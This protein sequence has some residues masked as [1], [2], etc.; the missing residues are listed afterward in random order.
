MPGWGFH[1]YKQVSNI[2][3]KV[4]TCNLNIF[5]E[6]N[7]ECFYHV[8]TYKHRVKIFGIINLSV[9]NKYFNNELHPYGVS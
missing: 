5:W 7:G 6:E 2:S 1:C 3:L 9:D 4:L 8:V